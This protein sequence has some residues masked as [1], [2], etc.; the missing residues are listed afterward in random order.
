MSYP[1]VPLFAEQNRNIEYSSTEGTGTVQAP[2][3]SIPFQSN[4]P[5]PPTTA[6]YD[7]ETIAERVYQILQN[8][9]KIQKARR[10]IG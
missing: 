6:N 9:I 2:L 3:I 7:I 4:N 10:G 5:V 1:T 8:K